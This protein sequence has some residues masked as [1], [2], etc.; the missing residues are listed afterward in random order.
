MDKGTV[1]NVVRRFRDA[2][3]AQ[4]LRVEKT[5]LYGAYAD[6]THREGSDID[7]VVVCGDT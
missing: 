6:G 7:L 4:G 3:E 1:L 2:L 5:V